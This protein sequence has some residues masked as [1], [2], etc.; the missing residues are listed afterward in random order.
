MAVAMLSPEPEQGKR[1][2]LA[3][4]GEVRISQQRLSDARAVLEYSPEL[5]L[6]PA[7]EKR[8]R[9]NKSTINGDFT[10][11]PHQRLSDAR[12]V[13]EYSPELMLRPEQEKGGRG[14]SCWVMPVWSSASSLDK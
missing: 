6:R 8:G 4:S 7:P 11:A 9:G 12:A 5:M 13:L 10:G 3:T 14:K 1:T 2:D